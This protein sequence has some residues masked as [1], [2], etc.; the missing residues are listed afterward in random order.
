MPEWTEA[1]RN[2]IESDAGEIIC[3]AAAGSGK[4]AVMV[5]RIAR[6]IRDGANQES[7]LIMTF[8]NAA[9]A[10]MKEKIRK[11]LQQDRHLDRFQHALD[12]MDSI[13]I[14]TI[15]SFCQQLIRD[16]FQLVDLDPDFQICDAGQ[17]RILFHQ[18]F[19]EA[20]D[21]MEQEEDPRFFRLR[22]L[23]DLNRAEKL[24]TELEPFILSLPDPFEWMDDKISSIPLSFQPDHPWMAG[25]N[26]MARD[27]IRTAELILRSMERMF[28]EDCA[29]E[30]YQETWEKDAELFHVKQTEISEN[31]QG[32]PAV[33]ARL[34]P[35]RN[36]TVQEIDW[37][38]RYKDQREKLKDCLQK[39]DRLKMDGESAC[40]SEWRNMQES[41]YAVE[42]LLKK[43]EERLLEL[44][45]TRGWADFHDLEH[46]AVQILSNPLGREEAHRTWRYVF[47]DE[48]Q[49]NSSVQNRIIDLLQ[50][51][52]NHLFM[53]GDVKQSI[54]RFR[55][56]EPGIFMRRIEEA[57]EKGQT[58]KCCI[59]LQSNFRSRPE[60]LSTA[61]LV[62]S[63]VMKK[64]VTEIEYGEEEKL[65]PGRKTEG[66][67]PVQIIQIDKNE[68]DLTDLEATAEFLR[69]EIAAL[70]KM[71]YEEKDR[72]FEYRD[73]V[74]LMPA[75]RPEGQKLARLL[76]EAKIPV[77]YD[78]DS[79][80]YELQ[81]IR[82]IRNLLE[83]IDY[84]LQDLPLISV[85]KEAP[86]DFSEEELSLIRLERPEKEA[87]FHEAFAA[88]LEK[89]GPLAEK[90]RRVMQKHREW[91]GWTKIM[92]V[93]DV[94]WKLY[95]D[96]GCYYIAGADPA[97][98]VRQANLRMLAQQASQAEAKGIF[99]LRK[100][101]DYMKD[102]QNYGDQ[103]SA[104]LLGDQDNLVRIMTVHKS[105]GLQFPVVF[106]AGMDRH[107]G[108]HG[109][110]MTGT[111]GELGLCMNYMDPDHRI[112][113]PTAATELFDW[114]KKREE[115]AE[116]VRLLYVAMTR[117]QEKLYM[118][119]C[120]EANP[121]WSMP[122]GDGRI[123]A[124]QSYT[125]WWM[126]VLLQGNGKNLSTSC[127]QPANP[128]E[129]R[130]FECNQQENVEKDTNIHS[131]RSWLETTL[132]APAVNKMWKKYQET[133]DPDFLVKRSVTSLIQSA[134]RSLEE[135]EETAERKRKPDLLSGRRNRP[136]ME[137]IPSFLKEE[138]KI[139]AAWRGTLTHRLLSLM[140]LERM[141]RGEDPAAVLAEEKE[142]MI[143][144]HMVS[145]AE[146]AGISDESIAAF[147]K[148]E[149]GK[150][151][152]AAEEVHREWN[153]NL[154]ISRGER[155]ILQGVI[156]CAFREKGE[157]VILDYKTDRG[158]SREKL[159]GEY[160][161]QLQWYA[162]AVHEL[163]GQP[164]REILL[165]SLELEESIPVEKGSFV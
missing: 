73:I 143:R 65:I 139:T 163:T 50:D 138:G 68:L 161:P 13:Q 81:E 149:T 164:V 105:K 84:P 120:R 132:S 86:F 99:T 59:R 134:R 34:K 153:F 96:T 100:F 18:A 108:G 28:S 14:S 165:Y 159:R 5:E 155:M 106:C 158:K 94:I 33:F 72:F 162:R 74:I 6:L 69:Q 51:P 88:V 85:L 136:E 61:N 128:Y 151:I 11:R 55:L 62:F 111:H 21:Q 38:D 44:K 43:T 1:Q 154:L 36:L 24:L 58:E 116:K 4:T 53:V 25:M 76:E 140:N 26:E 121:L 32:A 37:R 122:E 35:V 29:L 91:Q 10:E 48:C 113:R 142:R 115:T 150:R 56:A 141:R 75:V 117:A 71:K 22:Q 147:W 39:T 16:Q 146:I 131:L 7:F 112:S 9:A 98:E 83:W 3:S 144:E 157:W 90:C 31:R 103:Q 27:E 130:V 60:I 67:D 70:L 95:Q 110:A 126:P 20:C 82:M 107:P 160:S 123:L 114:K 145:P 8:T 40:F 97:G 102:Q 109:G 137:E 156:D 47:V 64:D 125:D 152:L 52:E 79:D 101:L 41:L 127:T 12:F 92:R 17:R 30:A 42:D 133:P 78:G 93:S 54:Y 57:S 80:Y 23:F 104:T 118:I 15:H 119:T 19:S 45:K 124:A 77:F 46:Y 89:E 135:E 66:R 63:A 49:D 2:V 129:I 87:S 148:S